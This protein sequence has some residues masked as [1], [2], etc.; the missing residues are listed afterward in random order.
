MDHIYTVLWS[1]YSLAYLHATQRGAPPNLLSS[2]RCWGMFWKFQWNAEIRILAL[3]CLLLFLASSGFLLLSHL[4]QKP[5]VTASD[6]I[7]QI[8][9]KFWIAAIV[10]ILGFLECSPFQHLF[11]AQSSC[12]NCYWTVADRAAWIFLLTKLPRS[13]EE[14]QVTEMKYMCLFQAFIVILELWDSQ[15]SAIGNQCCIN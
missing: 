7:W 14:S 3:S 8:R 2:R 6:S 5:H 11:H 9:F 1:R 13:S 10:S 12:Q 15:R 4:F